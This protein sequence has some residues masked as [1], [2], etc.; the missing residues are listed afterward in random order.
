[1]RP[2]NRCWTAWCW[3]NSPTRVA[4]DDCDCG[5]KWALAWGAG[6]S[7]YCYRATRS[8]F[9]GPTTKTTTVG[10]CSHRGCQRTCCPTGRLSY[11]LWS[12]TWASAGTHSPATRCYFLLMRHCQY[13]RG[14][15]TIPDR[16]AQIECPHNL[17]TTT[18]RMRPIPCL[19]HIVHNC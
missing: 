2:S 6:E 8:T 11:N 9:R 17:E 4:T 15:V 7:E 13:R 19:Y 3:I 16:L 1:M 10:Q 14:H 5:D 18:M 12:R